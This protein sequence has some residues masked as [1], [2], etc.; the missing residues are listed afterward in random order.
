MLLIG[1]SYAS[2]NLSIS[3]RF[4]NSFEYKFSKYSLMILWVSLTF[5]V[6]T[7]FSSLILLVWDFSHLLLVRLAKGLL[8]LFIFS[9]NQLFVVLTICMIFCFFYLCIIDF[10]L[11][12]YSLLLL[13]VGLTCSLR[14]LRFGIRSL[15]G[16]LSVFIT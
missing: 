2:R 6:I 3:S 9:K 16:D 14:S 12:F 10:S 4:S 5:A 8:L 15:I 7:L 11:Y 13:V 1:W